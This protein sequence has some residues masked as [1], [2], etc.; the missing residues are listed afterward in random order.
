VSGL[1]IAE[2]DHSSASHTAAATLL[3]RSSVKSASVVASSAPREAG[4]IRRARASH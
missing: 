4:S 3:S 2:I 1:C